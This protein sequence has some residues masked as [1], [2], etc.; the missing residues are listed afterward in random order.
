[1][2]SSKWRSKIILGSIQDVMSENIKMYLRSAKASNAL[3][4]GLNI[5]LVELFFG[6]Y[7]DFGSKII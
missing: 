3:K 5:C 4:V 1:M 2:T 6:V 7:T